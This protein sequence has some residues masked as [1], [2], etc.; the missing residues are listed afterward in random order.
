MAQTQTQTYTQS[1]TEL[2]L[3]LDSLTMAITGYSLS[4]IPEEKREEILDDCIKLF[5]NFIL[6]YTKAKYG[7]K[8][9][10]RIKSSL[11]FSGIDIF[12][13]FEDLGPKFDDA[14]QTFINQL[15]IN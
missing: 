15:E 11:Q 6:Q 7:T 12:T 9:Y 14:Y 2:Y 1:D 3:F 13:K 10:I 8:D 4:T 5:E